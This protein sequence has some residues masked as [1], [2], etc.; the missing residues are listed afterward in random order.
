MAFRINASRTEYGSQLNI[1]FTAPVA[2]TVDQFSGMLFLHNIIEIPL[3]CSGRC[4][5]IRA[6]HAFFKF[7]ITLFKAK[8]LERNLTVL[9][10]RDAALNDTPELPAFI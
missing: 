7:K 3:P 8:V 5:I 2:D 10:I 4:V 9:I 1:Q 6:F